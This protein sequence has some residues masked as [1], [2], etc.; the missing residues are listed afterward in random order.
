M[1]PLLLLAM[2]ILSS[3]TKATSSSALK[4]C[5]KLPL[6]GS[7]SRYTVSFEEC[8]LQAVAKTDPCTSTA[9]CTS[10]GS[11][12][13]FFK[14][15]RSVS[16]RVLGFR[17]YFVRTFQPYGLSHYVLRTI[18]TIINGCFTGK[19]AEL[20]FETKFTTACVLDSLPA[21]ARWL[22]PMLKR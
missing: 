16:K 4:E 13:I 8:V 1:K 17:F 19:A 15:L 14:H 20:H 9:S 2:I 18:H 10:R 5:Q 22:L 12:L 11:G 3:P 7:T 6:N 21:A